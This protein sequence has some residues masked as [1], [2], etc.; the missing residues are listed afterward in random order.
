[1]EF[2]YYTDLEWFH[3][4]LYC[5]N[6]PLKDTSLTSCILWVRYL[7]KISKKTNRYFLYHCWSVCTGSC[8]SCY[9]FLHTCCINPTRSCMRKSCEPGQHEWHDEQ[10]SLW[11]CVYSVC[12]CVWTVSPFQAVFWSGTSY[13]LVKTVGSW[14]GS[15]EWG[16]IW[17]STCLRRT[18]KWK[19]LVNI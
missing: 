6:D 10:W 7:K 2:P 15:R 4:V 14:V 17:S 9:L 19:S 18:K 5:G 11:V 13:A 1:M 8:L 3:G 12:V 16:Q